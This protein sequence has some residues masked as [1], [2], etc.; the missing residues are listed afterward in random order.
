MLRYQGYTV[1]EA[2]NGQEAI[3]LFQ[4][5]LTTIKLVILDLSMPVMNGEECL[6]HLKSIQL[7]VAVLLSSGYGETDATRRCQAAGVSIYLQ[8]PYTPRH[9]AEL[10]KSALSSRNRILGRA[11]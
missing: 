4:Q 8:K 2:S 6:K 3:E 7:D 11:A 5:N 1:L 9:L 10:V